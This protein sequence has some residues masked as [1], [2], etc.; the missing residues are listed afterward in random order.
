M[1]TRLK[2]MRRSNKK[3]PSSMQRCNSKSK[4]SQTTLKVLFGTSRK[5]PI[6]IQTDWIC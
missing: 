2:L 6:S 1:T 4:Q 5:A 3:R